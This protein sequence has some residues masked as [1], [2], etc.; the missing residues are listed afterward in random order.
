[1]IFH[2]TIRELE[3]L[4]WLQILHLLRLVKDQDVVLYGEILQM[5]I[6]QQLRS[7]TSFTY[8]PLGQEYGHRKG[9]FESSNE[10]FFS[11]V[12]HPPIQ[13]WYDDINHNSM[14]GCVKYPLFPNR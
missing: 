9:F 8:R 6:I 14:L 7:E 13:I 3:K 10:S 2:L 12:S 1:L 11:C 5:Y 4:K